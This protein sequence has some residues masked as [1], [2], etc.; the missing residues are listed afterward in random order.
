MPPAIAALIQH[1]LH[2]AAETYFRIF[3]AEGF[4]RLRLNLNGMRQVVMVF[5]P[6][7]ALSVPL[8]PAFG[9]KVQLALCAMAPYLLLVALFGSVSEMRLLLPFFAL[10]LIGIAQALRDTASLE[11]TSQR[12]SIL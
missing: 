12:N 5:A 2:I 10:L 3:F 4:H 7:L 11:A 9:R 6:V 1:R 8:F